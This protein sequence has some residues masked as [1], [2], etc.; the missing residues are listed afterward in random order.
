MGNVA[1]SVSH[2]VTDSQIAAKEHHG[3]LINPDVVVAV[4]L[5]DGWHEVADE[6]F[7]VDSIGFVCEE[8]FRCWEP[9]FMFTDTE[10]RW[11]HGPMSS[12]LAVH[13][14]VTPRGDIED[15]DNP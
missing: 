3:M 12:I 1:D 13:T 2:A 7:I 5:A 9:G 10:G 14:D 6:T 8:V 11:L 4:L 15:G